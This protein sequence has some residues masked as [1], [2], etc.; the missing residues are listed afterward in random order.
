[1]NDVKIYKITN[2]HIDEVTDVI[3]VDPVCG[4]KIDAQRYYQRMRSAFLSRGKIY[5]PGEVGCALA[6]LE[7]WKMVARS[8]QPGLIFEDDIPLTLK[9]IELAGSRCIDSNMNFIH[10]GIH[11]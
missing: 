5:T 1:M 3:Y 2:R 10:L 4:K 9:N 11:P 8:S 6:H 7:V